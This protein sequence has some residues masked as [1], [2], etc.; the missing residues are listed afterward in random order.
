MTETDGWFVQLVREHDEPLRRVVSRL[1]AGDRDRMDDVLQ[2]TYLRAF[3][4]IG[5]FRADADVGTWLHRIA[6]NACI[7]ELRRRGRQP[8][9]L[10]VRLFDSPSAVRPDA[11]VAVADADLVWR[12]LAALPLDQRVTVVLVDGEDLDH[13]SVA[14]ILGI[15]PGT[16]A[17]RL[18]RARQ[19]LRRLIGEDR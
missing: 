2:E 12:A 6:Y 7:D 10:G 5:D 13:E 15:A 19:N 9:P 17:T 14:A 4:S 16:V 3:R 1:L 18:H 11:A 8:V